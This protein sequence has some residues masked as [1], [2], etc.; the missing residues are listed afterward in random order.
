MKFIFTFGIFFFLSCLATDSS[1]KPKQIPQEFDSFWDDLAEFIACVPLK[2][3]N[4]FSKL[5]TRPPSSIS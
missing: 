1:F 5:T 4:Q 2:E 3:T